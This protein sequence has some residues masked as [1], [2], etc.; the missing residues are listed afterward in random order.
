VGAAHVL[1]AVRS[2]F[3]HAIE[4]REFFVKHEGVPGA[5]RLVLKNTLISLGGQLL[6]TPLSILVSAVMARHLGAGEFGEMYVAWMIAVFGFLFVEWGHGG[7]LPAAIARDRSRSGELLAAS[8]LWRVV[9]AVFVTLSLTAGCAL[10][11][12]TARFQLVLLLVIVQCLLQS[13]ANACQDAVRGFERTDVG[14]LGQVGTQLLS[15]M[16]VI[17]TLLLGGALF[18]VLIAQALGAAVVLLLLVRAIKIVGIRLSRPHREALRSLAVQGTPFLFFSFAMAAQPNIDA[19][20]LSKLAPAEVVGWHAVARRLIGALVLPG[21][22]VIGALYPT[23]CRLHKEDPAAYVATGR[24]ALRATLLLAVPIALSCALYRDLGIQIFSKQAYGG[25][26][27]NLVVLSCFLLLLYF[28]MPLGIAILAAGRQRMW[29]GVQLLCVLVSA[30]FNP[31]LIPWFQERYGNGGLG[32]CVAN[33]VAEALMVVAGVI[34]AP[35]GML[36]RSILATAARCL[37]A[38]LGMAAA[39]TALKGFSSFLAA[40]VALLSYLCCLWVVGGLDQSQ[41]ALFRS[42]LRRKPAAPA[43]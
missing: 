21:S 34:L 42:L 24:S 15:V 27:A 5:Q 11:G 40:P 2:I 4:Q 20:L 17:P 41:L 30:G 9:V 18:G 35:R 39:A 13:L 38:G 3:R 29:A 31:P 23:L 37:V 33:T 22:L 8:L 6:G 36:D 25:A 14:A 7:V 26:Q 28:S 16:L 10:L 43:T 19:V 32:V 1:R 12:Y